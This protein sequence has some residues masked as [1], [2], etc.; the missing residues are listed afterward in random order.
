MTEIIARRIADALSALPCVAGVV[1]GGSRAVGTA[2]EGSDVD[3]GV[4]YGMP[5]DYDAL[6]ALAA[7]LDDRRRE[8]LICREGGWGPWVNFGGWLSVSGVPVDLIF[9]DLHR[10]R[11]AV[12]ACDEGRVSCHY[13]AGHPHAYL[14]AMYRGELALCRVLYARDADFL[15]AKAG[16]ESYPEPM[17][18]ALL[19]FFLFEAQFSCDLA[20][21]YAR[22]GDACYVAGHLFRSVSALHQ[23]LFALN[24]AYCLNE[25]RATQR[26]EAL[27]R[28]PD[29]YARRID[30]LFLPRE[31]SFISSVQ[32]LRTLCAE[33]AALCAQDLKGV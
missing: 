25:K 5:P 28:R 12:R 24:R 4:Y 7:R 14:N 13:Q 16:A 2:V 29:G 31:G 20:E 17:R 30:A 22:S 1:L 27:P 21:K 9:R 32:V 15:R 33:A 3:I 8:G 10:V 6:N 11:Q 23:A 26:V 19:S 18:Q